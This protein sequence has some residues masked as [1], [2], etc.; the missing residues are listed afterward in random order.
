V[1][2][3]PLILDYAARVLRLGDRGLAWY[4]DHLLGVVVA[5]QL[6][7]AACDCGLLAC[8]ERWPLAAAAARFLFLGLMATLDGS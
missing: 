6:G 3:L 5:F 7:D 4:G 1:L 8:G 2:D